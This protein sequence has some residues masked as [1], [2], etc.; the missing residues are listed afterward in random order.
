M[1]V[2]QVV[3]LLEMTSPSKVKTILCFLSYDI[4]SLF[5]RHLDLWSSLLTLGSRNEFRLLSLNRS[6]GGKG[7]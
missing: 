1:K 5:R 2:K 4:T 3:L 6:L 7:G